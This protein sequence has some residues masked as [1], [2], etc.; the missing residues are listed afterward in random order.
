MT[1]SGRGVLVLLNTADDGAGGNLRAAVNIAEALFGSGVPATFSAPVGRGVEHRTVD[2]MDPGVERL[3]FPASGLFARFG[4]SLRQAWWLWRSVGSFDEVQTHSL[5]SLSA[6]YA[7][8]ICAVRG[9]PVVL[10][11][12]GSIDPFD[13]RKHARVKNALSPVLRR[14]ID[15]CEALFFTADQEAQVAVTWGSTTPRHVVP[16][17]V[18]PLD[19][20]GADP[21][22]WRMRHG[23]PADAPLVLCLGRIDYKKRIPLLVETLGLLATTSAHLVIVGDGPDSERKLVAE[24]AARVRVNDRVHITGWL[25]GADRVEAF[26]AATVFALLSDAENFGLSIVEAMSVG[27]PVV[28]S[29]KVSLSPALIKAGAAVVVPQD[30]AVAAGELDRLLREPETAS[31]LGESGREFVRKQFAPSAVAA[32]LSELSAPYSD[33]NTATRRRTRTVANRKPQRHP[34]DRLYPEIA[35]GGYA[36]RDGFIDFFL[37]VRTLLNE[38]DVVL[39]FGAGRAAWNEDPGAPKVFREIRDFRT[40]GVKVIGVD[41]DPIVLE[42]HSVDESYLIEPAGRLPLGDA[43]VDVIVADHV[44]EHV[45]RED[46]PAVVDELRRVLKPGGWICA[47]TPN[48]WGAIGVAA[49]VV[50]NDKH[51]ATLTKLQPNREAQDV[52][53]VRYAM[54]T[55]RDLRRL[56][57]TGAWTLTSYGHPGV[58]QYAGSSVAA[59]RAA[60]FLDRITPPALSPTWMIFVRKNGE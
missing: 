58:Q 35:A 25:E 13:L 12:H 53:P 11:P 45:S 31:A 52:F 6:V 28:V 26:A 21:A 9:V 2:L 34:A 46:A 29:G 41:V 3:L 22:A 42:N 51:V 5:F 17:P 1:A 19:T 7:I 50:P 33:S 56:F 44:F 60:A 16:L 14:L 39:D 15:R 48:K 37:R 8:L 59:W 49:R 27:L 38:G 18:A 36:R 57:P 23:L 40:A 20:I 32:R 30:P 47:R 10:W 55:P 54:N 4:G 43:L 24:A